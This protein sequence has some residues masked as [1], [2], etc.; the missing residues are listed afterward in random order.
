[1]GIKQKKVRMMQRQ[2][3]N[4]NEKWNSPNPACNYKHHLGVYIEFIIFYLMSFEIS[5]EHSGDDFI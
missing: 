1:M 2:K 4:E 3:E 5:S